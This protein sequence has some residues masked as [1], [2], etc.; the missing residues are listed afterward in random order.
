MSIFIIVSLHRKLQKKKKKKKKQKKKQKLSIL[1]S[2]SGCHTQSS[3]SIR[4]AQQ[5]GCVGFRAK[6]RAIHPRRYMCLHG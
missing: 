4:T 2:S 3:P 1:V 6:V 5:I